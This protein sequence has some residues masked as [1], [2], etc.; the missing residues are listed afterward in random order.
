MGDINQQECVFNV[1]LHILQFDSLSSEHTCTLYNNAVVYVCFSIAL[2]K[3]VLENMVISQGH[4]DGHHHGH[5]HRHGG[6]HG[7]GH[8]H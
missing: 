3:D 4:G 5:G 6:G 2:W 8:E 7:H 1:T